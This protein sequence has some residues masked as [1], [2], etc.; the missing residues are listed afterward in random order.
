MCACAHVRVRVRVPCVCVYAPAY[1]RILC[2][3]LL[4][5]HPVHLRVHV[6]VRVRRTRSG[7][8]NALPAVMGSLATRSH[9]FLRLL[10][11]KKKLLRIYTQN[12]DGLE[13]V[14]GLDPKR[15]VY[16]THAQRSAWPVCV[17]SLLS[18]DEVGHDLKA[19]CALSLLPFCTL[20]H[21]LGPWASVTCGV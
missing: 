6:R 12:V 17:V 1:M 2:V 19:T 18:I 11:D 14:A 13:L 10:Q 8:C 15:V 3:W 20:Y 5:A 7:M 21:V 9:E 16:V 4:Y